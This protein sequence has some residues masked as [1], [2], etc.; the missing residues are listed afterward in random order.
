MKF[1]KFVVMQDDEMRL[2]H[3]VDC[4]SDCRHVDLVSVSDRRPRGAGSIATAYVVKT[5]VQWVLCDRGSYG[6]SVGCE[7]ELAEQVLQTIN[8]PHARIAF[9]TRGDSRFWLLKGSS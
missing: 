5:S 3:V 1:R 2:S 9:R 6:L 8:S 7:L 4:L